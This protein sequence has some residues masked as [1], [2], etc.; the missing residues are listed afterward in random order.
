MPLRFLTDSVQLDAHFAR[1]ASLFERVVHKATYGE[2]EV[3]D[4]YRLAQQGHITVGMI[5]QDGH[6]QLAIAFE[7]IT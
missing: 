7:F 1:L 3:E 6:V 5:E 4:L 2:F